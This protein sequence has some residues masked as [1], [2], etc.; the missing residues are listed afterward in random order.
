M[1]GCGTVF[2][3]TPSGLENVI[4]SFQDQKDGGEPS[5]ALIYQDGALYGTSSDFSLNHGQGSVFKMSLS[6]TEHTIYQFKGGN[7]GATPESAL[8]YYKGK[9]YGTTNNGGSSCTSPSGPPGCGTVFST[10]LSGAEHVLHAFKSGNDGAAPQGLIYYGGAFYGTTY[11]GGGSCKNISGCG[12]LFSIEPSGAEKVL[13][14]FRSDGYR[15]P[16]DLVSVGNTL[17][18]TTESGPSATYGY[19]GALYAANP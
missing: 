19:N 5:A 6:G 1:A 4:Y 16:N 7:D 18:G 8:V 9:L 14:R 17:Y 11:Y 10:T 13:Y 3:I 12:T 2:T 15:Q